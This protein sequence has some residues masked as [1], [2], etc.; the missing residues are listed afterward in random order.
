MGNNVT[1]GIRDQGSG[2]G[3]QGCANQ[4]T[5]EPRNLKPRNLG[6]EEPRNLRNRDFAGIPAARATAAVAKNGFVD[7]AGGAQQFAAALDGARGRGGRSMTATRV[8]WS[9]SG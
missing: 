3:D 6:T 9:R 1:T 5:K 8:R 7:E 2:I 4:A